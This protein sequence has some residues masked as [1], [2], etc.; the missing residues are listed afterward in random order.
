MN[1]KFSVVIAN[2][3]GSIF[4]VAPII[5]D[6]IKVEQS[7]TG[8]PT[9]MTF[10]VCKVKGLKINLGASVRFMYEGH[11]IFKGFVFDRTRNSD[12]FIDYICYDQLRYLKNKDTFIYKNKTCGE[13]VKMVCK[14]FNLK[15]GTVDNGSYKIKKRIE[16]NK[17]LFDVIN[18]A[19][20]L[21]E[22]NTGKIYVLYDDFGKIC[23]RT[24]TQL[25]ITPQ[26]WAVTAM[27][28]ED[29]DYNAS[30]DK[31]TYNQILLYKDVET[32]KAKGSKSGSKVRKRYVAKDSKNIGKWGILQY[33]EK[34][35][36]GENGKSKADA[37]LKY[38]D[39]YTRTLTLKGVLGNYKVRAGSRIWVNLKLGD[40]K[41]NS[42]VLV[43]KAVHTFKDGLYLMELT[44]IGGESTSGQ[45]G[46]IT[47]V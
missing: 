44:V 12:Q 14:K 17:T 34:I 11:K 23:L 1:E 29:F 28:L 35:E 7:R 15:T 10:T 32:K 21:E 33:T 46:V 24:V 42:Y 3:P 22:D 19:V 43:E 37:L 45:K 39:K 30:I 25:T 16:D 8:S 40:L 27:M 47:S 38:Y 2:S 4:E 26:N 20:N 41:L 18:N 6:D 31:E 9:K 13:V 5:K 36:D